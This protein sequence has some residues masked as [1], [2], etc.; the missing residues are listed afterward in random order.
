[1][2]IITSFC[3]SFVSTA[4]NFEET[5]APYIIQMMITQDKILKSTAAVQMH[6]A[7][8][9][10]ATLEL[11]L[12]E[13][14]DYLFTL[15]HL[16]IHHQPF[17]PATDD[18]I[19]TNTAL[20]CLIPQY[21]TYFSKINIHMGILRMLLH[22]CSFLFPLFGATGSGLDKVSSQIPAVYRVNHFLKTR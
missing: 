14:M 15:S 20:H 21:I 10:F 16:A 4:H 9:N 12:D 3:Q 6:W 22:F 7:E 19:P 2:D 11:Y 8:R 13:T 17:W 1:M 18:V 5:T